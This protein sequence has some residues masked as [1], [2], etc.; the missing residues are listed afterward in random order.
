LFDGCRTHGSTLIT[1]ALTRHYAL[2]AM[3]WPNLLAPG[4]RAVSVDL[5]YLSRHT[6]WSEAMCYHIL[7]GYLAFH[8]TP[9]VCSVGCVRACARV[10]ARVCARVRATCARSSH[11]SE[12]I[13]HMFLPYVV[14]TFGPSGLGSFGPSG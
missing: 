3:G 10:R 11:S 6:P 9:N 5:R 12:A 1:Y 7:P 8:G 4:C 2:L 14:G 13:E